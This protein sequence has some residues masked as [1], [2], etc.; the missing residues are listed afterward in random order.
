M[1]EP[2]KICPHCKKEVFWADNVQ[3][4]KQEEDLLRVEVL[5]PHCGKDFELFVEND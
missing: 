3:S 4:E 1:S 5:C 2:H